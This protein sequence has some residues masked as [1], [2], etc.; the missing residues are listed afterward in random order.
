MR[1]SCNAFLFSLKNT[2]Q[3]KSILVLLE[4]KVHVELLSLYL[5]LVFI[6]IVFQ[7][8]NF[9]KVK[10]FKKPYSFF[11]VLICYSPNTI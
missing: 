5:K 4:R 7:C 10:S 3:F 6:F 11:I 2:S 9:C 8:G 1:N